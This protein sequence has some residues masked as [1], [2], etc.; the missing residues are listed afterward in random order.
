MVD[1]VGRGTAARVNW[2]TGSGLRGKIPIAGKTGT[3]Q[4]NRDLGFSG[5]TPYYTASIWLGNDNEK[6]MHSRAR[7]FHLPAWGR[8]MEEIH[9]GLPARAFERPAGITTA[10]VCRDSG[11]SPTELCNRDPRGR[12]AGSDLFVLSQVPKQSCNVHQEF[13]YCTES[14]MVAGMGCPDWAVVTRVG[15]VRPTPVEATVGDSYL[16]F[17]IAI[18]QGLTCTMHTGLFGSDFGGNFW[19]GLHQN[20]EFILDMVTGAWLPNPNYNPMPTPTPNPDGTEGQ[21][22]GQ[23]SDFTPE[24]G[25]GGHEFPPFPQM[26]TFTPIPTPSP[27]PWA[28]LGSATE[29]FNT[30]PPFVYTVPLP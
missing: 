10:S 13:T 27:T 8:I 11:H 18:R 1:T 16:E 22:Q 25:P 15:I 17:P 21:E 3:S 5:F 29:S 23:S 7:E 4:S 24:A 2:S 9:I 19:D 12:R 20:Q 6:P 26:P 30:P 28:G 14:V